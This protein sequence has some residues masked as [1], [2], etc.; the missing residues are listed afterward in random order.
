MAHNN[1]PN[2]SKSPLPER[3]LQPHELSDRE[4]L[5]LT[6]KTL[7]NFHQ[8]ALGKDF[9]LLKSYITKQPSADLLVS[10]VLGREKLQNILQN[11]KNTK[12]FDL[13]PRKA[14]TMIDSIRNRINNNVHHND[15]YFNSLRDDINT[16]LYAMV[17]I[18]D[19]LNNLSSKSGGRRRTRRSRTRRSKSRRSRK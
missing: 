11:L 3:N 1:A 2:F 19:N 16:L 10:F 9:D 6:I 7:N 14:Q 13:S 18:K 5:I 8:A 12:K 4:L 15:P 17:S